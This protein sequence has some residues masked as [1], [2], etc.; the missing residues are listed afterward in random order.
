MKSDLVV[1]ISD[2]FINSHNYNYEGQKN[3]IL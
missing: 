1:K 3:S 2:G